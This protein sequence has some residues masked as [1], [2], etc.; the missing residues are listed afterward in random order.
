MK[1]TG[2]SVAQAYVSDALGITALSR[3]GRGWVQ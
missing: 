1:G 2:F 3:Q